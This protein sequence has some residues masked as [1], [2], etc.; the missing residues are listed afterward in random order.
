MGHIIGIKPQFENI[1]KNGPFIP[2]AAGQRKPE[3]Q[4]T[5]DERKAANLDQRLKSLIIYKALMNELV[6]DVIQLSK[7]KI[8]TNFINGLP[9]K[10]L[11]FC[12]SLRNINHVKDY[13]LASLFGKLKYEENL[14]DSIYETEKNK[15]LVS[16]TPLS[17]AFFS[18]FIVQDIQDSPNDEE[19]TRSSPEYL[20]DLEEEYQARALLA[21]S[22]RFFKKTSVLSYQS[23]FQS[24]LLLSSGNKPEPR[25]AKDFEAKYHKVKA[26]LALLS[27][28]SSDENE[29]TEDKDL[30]A[31][32]DEER[33]SV[34]KESARNETWLNSSNKVNQC[35]SKQIPT[36]KKKILGIYQLTED[37]SNYR[38]KDLV[39]VKSSGNNSYVSITGS[40]KPKLS[41]VEDSILPNYYTG[42]VPSNESQR[43]RIDPSV[44]VSDSSTTNYDSADESLVCSTPLPPL[45]KLAGVKPI[46]GPKTIK[47]NLKS[48]PTFKDENLKGITLKEPS[49]APAKD[50]KK[51]SSASKTSSVPAGKLRNVKIED[52]PPLAIVIKELNE[53]KLQLSKK[54]SSHS[55]NHQSRQRTDHRTCDHAEFMSTIKTSQH[56]TGQGEYFLRSRPSTPRNQTK[57]PSYVTKNY[58][59]CGS[60]VHTK[61]DHND[62]E[63][64]RKGEAKKAGANKIVLSNVQRSKT[65]TQRSLNTYPLQMKD[66]LVHDTILILFNKSDETGI[67]IKKARLV[68]Q[69]YNQQKGIDCNGTF[70]PVARL[71]AIRIF[72]AFSTYIN[73][74]GY[75]M[76][77]KSTFL[78]DKLKEEVYVNQPPGFENTEFP[79][80][81]F[82]L[83]KAV[84]EL[85]ESPR[86]REPFTRSPNMYKEYLDEFWYSAKALENSKVSFSIPI[87]GIYEEVGVNTFRNAIGDREI[88]SVKWTFK[89]NLL[90]LRWRL[91]M[92]QIIQCLGGGGTGG[93]DQITNKDVIILYSLANGINI[94]YANIFW[95]DIIIKL[96]KK[97]RE[98]VVPYT[99]FLSLLMI[100]NMKEGYRDAKRVVFK[101]PKLSSNAER[102]SQGTKPKAQPRHKK[103]STSSKLPFVSSK[104]ATKGVTSEERADPQLSS[105]MSVFNLNKPIYSASFIIHSESA[106]GYD[107]SANSTA[108]AAPGKFA[109]N[110]FIPQQHDQTQSVSEGL[111][112]A[113]N[114]STSDKVA[115]N[116]VKQ[117]EEVEAA[118]AI[119]LEDLA[120]LVQNVQPSFKDPDSPEDDHI[121]IVDDSDE[122]EEAE[123][124]GLHATLN[125]ETKDALVPKSLSLR[126]SQI[127]EL[128]NQVHIRQS[129]KHKLELEKNKAK[130]K[131]ALLKAQPSFPNDLRSKFNELI[132][133]VKGLKKQVR[134][135]EIELLGDLKEIP[136][137]LEDFTKT[138]TSLTSQVTELKTLQW[139]LLAEFLSVPTQVEMVQAKLKTLDALLSLL[140]KVTN[141]LNQFAQAIT[142]KKTEDTSIPSAG[143]AGTQPTEGE[144]N[145]NQTTISQL[146]QRKKEK[147]KKAISSEEAEKE[148]TS[149]DSDHETHLTGSMVESSK[150]KKIKKFDFVT[151]GGKHIHLTKEEIN[152]QKKIEEEAKAKA[153]KRESE[154]RKEELVDLL[155]LESF[156][157]DSDDETHLTGSMVESSKAKK[158]KKF[159]FVTKGGKHIHLT[160][161]EINHQKKIEEEAKAK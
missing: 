20:N 14:I 111:Q 69:G 160:E 56:L 87:G 124:D 84:Y 161:E 91:L 38:P 44:V 19:D 59:T 4:W 81:V 62:I 12:Q 34:G 54:K 22:K 105:G 88:V 90:P 112:T 119:K 143:Q 157:S 100:H 17:T 130:A 135:L 121:I 77:I 93:F 158:I 64:F 101:A 71:K 114:Q 43:N 28:M 11:S 134:E 58:E 141:A 133:E 110:D 35:I 51:G 127:Q 95:E 53:L 1:I 73:F 60:N 75:Q 13:E 125:N 85:K 52:D 5:G 48:N 3:G 92:V 63:L 40:N 49:S 61:T 113:L 16:T 131:V 82:K 153:D 129:Q 36:Q 23:P 159:D 68:A 27:S 97:Q 39:F 66:T 29:V 7:L 116:I 118:S 152:H 78:N 74:I 41:K 46:S 94:D 149:S 21:K 79:N 15:S 155:V 146:F 55:R 156:S 30:M 150:A 115:S 99:R 123:K 104:E 98:K 37:T 72:L 103:H 45:E 139:E 50:N 132:E 107:A 70:A 80:H 47:S 109:P 32:T 33:V 26:K 106:S 122:D 137:K 117:I 76:D 148:S 126:S 42:K 8:N 65:P 102:V 57:K 83:D 120:K 96:N 86:A 24:K 6:N 10:W 128:T 2:I 154:V 67:V 31:L 147:G 140:N 108:K 144:K 138:I 151:E 145:T 89:K 9:K 142:S 18:T 136:T 25:Q